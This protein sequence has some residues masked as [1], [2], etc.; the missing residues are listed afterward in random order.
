MAI[1]P[2]WINPQLAI[3]PRPRGSDWLDDEM[4]ALRKAGIDIVVSLLDKFEARD[5]GLSKEALAATCAG[6]EFIHF[7]IQDGGVPAIEPF[8][9]F[10]AGL[11]QA[12]ADGK[13]IGIH[14]FGG[15]GRSSVA[16][17]SLLIRS[18][19]PHA[20]AWAQIAAARGAPVP[21]TLA[22]LHWVH[23]NIRPKA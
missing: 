16:A 6:L 22:Q 8:D 2:F 14:C 1:E 19:V 13:R 18:G 11:E 12:I 15:I 17:A 21:D 20:A 9:A 4:L 7:P 23:R 3:V 10:L 5:V